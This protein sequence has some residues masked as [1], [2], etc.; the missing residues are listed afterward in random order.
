[1]S[2]D[3]SGAESQTYP[4]NIGFL[5]SYMVKQLGKN[6]EVS[7]FLSVDELCLAIRRNPPDFLGLSYYL[8]NSQL[9]EN[10]FR[11]AKGIRKDTITIAGGPNT[12]MYEEN[13][14]AY[15][16]SRHSFLDFIIVGE[17]EQTLCELVKYYLG[18]RNMNK[19]DV[20]IK[21]LH[22]YNPESGIVTSCGVR[23]RIKDIDEVIP[24]PILNHHLDKFIHL[25]PMIQGVRGCPYSC[26]YCHMGS[27]YYN[28]LYHFSYER[29]VDEI[30]YIR[31][32][33]ASQN[34][35]TFTDDNFGMFDI[36]LKIL[37]YCQK[38][39]YDTGWPIQINVAT[40]KKISKQFAD[41]LLK[42]KDFIRVACHFQSLND[43][44]LEFIKRVGP[45]A[46]ELDYI[47]KNFKET[48][49]SSLSE[50]A[51]IIPMPYETYHTYRNA[52]R[53]IIDDYRIEHCAVSTLSMF[54]GNVFEQK[55]IQ[56]QFA[57][58]S[59]YRL[60]TS[61]F[62]EFHEFSSYEVERVC[63]ETNTFS[64]SEYYQ[65]RLFCLGSA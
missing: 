65:A 4:L 6:V 45:T 57:M 17:G 19:L 36:D 46:S 31:K 47:Y 54:W 30:E 28:K 20:D 60:D 5:K 43:S 9:S 8:W 62:G 32:H 10:I 3:A 37:E 11:F 1:M 7:L 56:E 15:W 48:S 44:T 38:S 23:E 14:A 16:I 64:E 18:N 21:G 59:M 2:Y 27:N 25:I 55:Q 22:Y 24:S 63:V 61:S 26:K 12:P 42:T 41:V 51:L 52:M 49:Y 50:T 58:K 13:I 39:Y 29:L 40:A 35:I 33:N 34:I 53:K